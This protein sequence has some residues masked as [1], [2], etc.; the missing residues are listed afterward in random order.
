VA[1]IDAWRDR[2]ENSDRAIFVGRIHRPE[3]SDVA[4]RGPLARFVAPR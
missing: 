4:D 2:G 1:R 3:S